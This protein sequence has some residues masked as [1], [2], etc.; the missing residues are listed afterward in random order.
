MTICTDQDWDE[1]TSTLIDCFD[2]LVSQYD[3]KVRRAI[4]SVQGH[5]SDE[6]DLVQEVFVRLLIRLRRPG[7]L[8]VGAWLWRVARNVAIDDL[9]Q[10][11][12]RSRA[13]SELELSQA[14]SFEC[15]HEEGLHQC[16]SETFGSMPERQRAAL[17]EMADQG[18]RSSGSC[19][20]VAA[21]L[22][23]TTSVAEG[24]LARGRRRLTLALSSSGFGF[25]DGSLVASLGLGVTGWLR[26]VR[27]TGAGHAVALTGV[28]GAA[29][30]PLAV[31]T[32]YIG[33]QP[34]SAP[35]SRPAESARSASISHGAGPAGR[36]VKTPAASVLPGRKRFNAS[37]HG[38][39]P[40]LSSPG[41]VMSESDGPDP[42]TELGS[43]RSAKLVG[44]VAA[45]ASLDIHQLVGTTEAAT[46]QSGKSGPVQAPLVNA[47]LRQTVGAN[48]AQPPQVVAQDSQPLLIAVATAAPLSFTP[49]R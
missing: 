25:R 12:V 19:Q 11:T 38:Q 14:V 29:L 33:A 6:D 1:D 21:A 5:T 31:A 35:G 42:I 15:R 37:G 28:A 49:S 44:D 36:D 17:L 46:A 30:A 43:I 8:R 7:S 23:V 2:E 40:V 3:V 16:L 13:R 18:A 41:Q 4:R 26:W 10:K 27:R 34:G 9:R 45:A 22:G 32:F 24:L 47:Q 39:T 20:A 48:T